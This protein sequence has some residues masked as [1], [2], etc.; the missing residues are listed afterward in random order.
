[1]KQKQE[2]ESGEWCAY[3]K[4]LIEL[5]KDYVYYKKQFYHLE[6]FCTEHDITLEL[7]IDAE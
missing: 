4:E 3:C 7:E 6:C 1:M 2:I 5:N